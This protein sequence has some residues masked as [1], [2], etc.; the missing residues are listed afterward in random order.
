VAADEFQARRA[1]VQSQFGERKVDALIVPFG[2]NLRYLTGFT[3]SNGLLLMP[4]QGEALLYTD[5][6]YRIQAAQEVSCQ[7][8]VCVGPLLP[9][10]IAAVERGRARRLGFDPAHTSCA[11]YESLRSGLRLAIALEGVGGWIERQRMIKSAAEIEL[12]RRS[13]ET[14]SAAFEQ[15][16]RQARAGMRESDLAAELDYRMRRKGAEAPAFETIVAAGAR[17]ALPHARPTAAPIKAGDLVLVDMG[18]MQDGYASDM[19]RMLHL[20][21]PSARAKRMYRAVLEAQQAA[22]DAVRP[23]VTAMHVDRAARRVLKAHG[24]DKAFV[25]STGH[26]LGLE[27][28]EPPRVGR[29]EKTRLEAGMAITIEPGAYLEGVGGIRI[30]DTVVV[31]RGGCQVLTPTPK[32][33]RVI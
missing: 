2:P 26:G 8:R 17:T 31:T 29:K 21:R 6:R 30:E 24:L 18:A 12:I 16:V 13:V 1:R 9:R 7:V 23:G 33:L 5:P 4:A 20:G 3:G 25:H 27:I 15:A 14:N 32:E 22:V 11:D 19:T 10:L 28:H